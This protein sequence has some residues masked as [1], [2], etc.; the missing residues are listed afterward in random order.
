MH[1]IAT[2]GGGNKLARKVG[3]SQLQL[4]PATP[5]S[6]ARLPSRVDVIYQKIYAN[7]T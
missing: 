1:R 3:A 6:Y 2:Y 5:A 7:H 4:A